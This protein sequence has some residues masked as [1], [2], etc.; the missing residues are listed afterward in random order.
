MDKNDFL[1]K[2]HFSALKV[3]RPNNSAT[4]LHMNLFTYKIVIA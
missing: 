3:M 2:G 4:K 1:F